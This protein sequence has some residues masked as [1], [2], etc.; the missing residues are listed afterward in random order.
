MLAWTGALV[1]EQTQGCEAHE[2]CVLHL[3]KRDTEFPKAIIG[4]LDNTL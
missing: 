3:A 2:T 4:S 1:G